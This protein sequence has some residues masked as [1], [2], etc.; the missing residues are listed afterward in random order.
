ME[1]GAIE[2]WLDSIATVDDAASSS[3]RLKEGNVVMEVL[4]LEDVPIICR[5]EFTV[6][7]L[8]C[9]HWMHQSLKTVGT[10]DVEG[11]LKR[12]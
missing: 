11:S 2:R 9:W 3:F 10:V 6:E 1:K 7:T 12:Q 8:A 5:F 4:V